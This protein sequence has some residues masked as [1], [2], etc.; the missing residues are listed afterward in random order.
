VPSTT[1]ALHRWLAARPEVT[2]IVCVS[3][4]T[5]A[6]FEHVPHKAT[7]IHNA[8]DLERFRRGATAGCAKGKAFPTDA[9]VFGST[10]RVL[11]RK[12]YPHM[13]RAARVLLDRATDAERARVR[14]VVVGDTPADL[15]GDHLGECRALIRELGLDAVFTMPGFVADVRPWLEDFNVVVLPSVYP[16]PLPRTVIESMAYTTPVIAF[17][18]GGVGEMVRDGETGTLMSPSP[19]P[20]Q[21][22]EVMLS[23]LR[24]PARVVREGEQARRSVESR[25]NAR[26]HAQS[27]A[28]EIT[29]AASFS[30]L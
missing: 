25:F 26:A 5:A 24:D 18:V 4:A 21:L 13:I 17:D 6:L 3:H 27:I 8:V 16:D 23:Y 20:E 1:R 28:A 22:A 2:R 11:P 19:T 10:G 9:F 29:R 7:V 15:P 12:G 30:A 14:F